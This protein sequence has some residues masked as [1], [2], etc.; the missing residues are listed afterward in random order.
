MGRRYPNGEVVIDVNDVAKALGEAQHKI[1]ELT[2]RLEDLERAYNKHYHSLFS[3][4]IATF[5]PEPHAGTR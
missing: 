2:K 5:G 1:N 3:G 4:A